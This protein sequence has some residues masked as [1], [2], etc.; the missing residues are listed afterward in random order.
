VELEVIHVLVEFYEIV[1]SA[2][3]APVRP[4]RTME[5]RFSTRHRFDVLVNLPTK[6]VVRLVKIEVQELFECRKVSERC[7]LYGAWYK[8]RAWKLPWR[9]SQGAPRVDVSEQG[10]LFDEITWEFAPYG[11]VHLELQTGLCSK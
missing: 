5:P 8:V 10:D 4:V 3:H 9:E 2:P 7:W 6:H 1:E 11:G